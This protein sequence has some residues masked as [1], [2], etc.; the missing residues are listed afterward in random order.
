MARKRGK[1]WIQKALR[2]SKKGSLKQWAR[3]HRF[4]SR[5]GNIR[6]ADAYGYAKRHK[7]THRMRQ[8][9]LA[10]NLGRLR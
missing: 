7:L 3:Q 4:V 6:L 5:N 10:R 1:R 2:H 9:N 8:I